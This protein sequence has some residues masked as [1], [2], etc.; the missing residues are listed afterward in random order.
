MEAS[1]PLSIPLPCFIFHHSPYHFLVL[2]NTLL[3]LPLPLNCKVRDLVC[4]AYQVTTCI[5][6]SWSI[7]RLTRL[8]LSSWI[9][10]FI[11]FISKT[12]MWSKVMDLQLITLT[13]PGTYCLTCIRLNNKCNTLPLF[14]AQHIDKAPS[15]TRVRTWRLASHLKTHQVGILQ[16]HCFLIIF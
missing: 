13:E 10:Y 5:Y 6:N 3:L 8:G 1:A 11:V 16:E 12:W 14:Q 7:I 9:Y 15:R 2:F 4:F